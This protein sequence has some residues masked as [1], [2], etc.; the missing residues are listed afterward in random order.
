M[1]GRFLRNQSMLLSGMLKKCPWKRRELSAIFD[2][3]S[4]MDCLGQRAKDGESMKLADIM[5]ADK[6]VLDKVVVD[7]I[8]AARMKEQNLIQVDNKRKSKQDQWG[9]ILVER[10]RRRQDKTSGFLSCKGLW[11]WKKKEKL[12]AYER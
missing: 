2:M 11:S 1:R 7:S 5:G 3:E 6:E 10:Q 4:E 12:R 9:P 8:V